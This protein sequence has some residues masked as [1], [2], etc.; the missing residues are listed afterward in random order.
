MKNTQEAPKRYLTGQAYLKF[1]REYLKTFPLR[2]PRE[3]II[4]VFI[5]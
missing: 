3:K 2:K 5:F 1:L 4:G